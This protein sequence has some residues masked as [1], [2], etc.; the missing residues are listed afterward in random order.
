MLMVKYGDVDVVI[1]TDITMNAHVY[2]V[3]NGR[4][5]VCWWQLLNGESLVLRMHP[6]HPLS[7]LPRQLF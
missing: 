6:L 7:I 4:L 2:M 1:Y 5:G 3:T